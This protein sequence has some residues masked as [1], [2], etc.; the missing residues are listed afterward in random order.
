MR[1]HTCRGTGRQQNWQPEVPIA[2]SKRRSFS[3]LPGRRLAYRTRL[4]TDAYG[5]AQN[6]FFPASAPTWPGQRPPSSTT[7]APR[8]ANCVRFDYSGHGASNGRFED[9]TIGAWAQDAVAVIDRVADGPLVLVGSSMGGWIMLLAALAR[10]N[11]RR[12]H[13]P[14]GA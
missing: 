13:R 12:A 3:I 14:R 2:P 6:P 1:H 7:L 11:H 8:A 5:I 10:P 9:G 4:A